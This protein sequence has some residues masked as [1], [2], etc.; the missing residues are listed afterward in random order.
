LSHNVLISGGAL[1]LAAGLAWAWLAQA[2]AGGMSGDH[3]AMMTVEPWT[4]RYLWPA[5]IM[6]ALM[7]VA[8]MLPSAAPMILLHARL[9]KSPSSRA[10]LLHTLLF[11]STYLLVWAAFSALAAVLQAALVDTGML[12]AATLQLGNRRMAGVLLLAAAAYQ[13]SGAKAACLDQCRS[14]IHFVM[15]FWRPGA[16]GALRLGTIHGVYCLGC[17]W[18]LMLLLFAGGVMN[19]AWVAVLA[20]AV[21]IEKW[22]PPQWRM[23]MLVAGL[24]AFA[25]LALLATS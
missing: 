4:A 25:G 5:F 9:D 8:M 16:A 13:L 15:R 23:S 6:W 12:D 11:A 7:M 18:V 1:I 22:S 3:M 20:I 2:G 19:L 24:L 14:P 10:R 21:S 17:C